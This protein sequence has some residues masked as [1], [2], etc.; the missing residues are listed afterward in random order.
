LGSPVVDAAIMWERWHV[1]R[2]VLADGRTAVVK[3]PRAADDQPE[4][5]GLEREWASLSLLADMPSPVVPRLL[6]GDPDLSLLVLEE[7]PEGRSM[8]E[9]LINGSPDEAGAALV[10]YATSLASVHDFTAG[11]S[12]PGLDRRPIWA[13]RVLA[14]GS[15][16]TVREREE[17]ARLLTTTDEQAVLV[18]GDPCPDNVH[19][20]GGTC[21]LIDFERTSFGSAVLDLAYLIAPWPSCWCFGTLPPA[22]A[23]AALAA[24]RSVRP[25]GDGWE[26]ELAAAL[27][28][29]LIYRTNVFDQPDL[30]WGTTT[31]APRL[32]TWTEAFLATP[33]SQD[34]PQLRAD[35]QSLHDQVAVAGTRPVAYPSLPRPGHAL[36]ISP[37]AWL[38]SH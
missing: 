11:R 6:G 35:A 32:L 26:S 24:Y 34:W 31:W 9:V 5:M 2:V 17:V 18:H 13:Q 27:A 21:W 33:A 1:V 30:L 16:G 7:L 3:R 29:F 8:A 4:P 15:F 38:P 36:A 12:A 20:A 22:V 14:A 23:D 25:L 28:A 37:D 10:A 19:L